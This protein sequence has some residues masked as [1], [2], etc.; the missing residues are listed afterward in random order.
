M[1]FTF[2]TEKCSVSE[3]GFFPYHSATWTP[4]L[5]QL[6][7]SLSPSLSFANKRR[8]TAPIEL[9]RRGAAG[10][11]G[12]SGGGGGGGKIAEQRNGGREGGIRRMAPGSTGTQKPSASGGQAAHQHL[13]T[14]Q[15]DH[16]PPSQ[17]QMCYLQPPRLCSSFNSE[18]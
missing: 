13:P 6:F 17:N 8:G 2:K 12:G 7:L 11:G 1:R 15:Q 14:V 10:G 5:L 16:D 3:R 18:A 4:V 9:G